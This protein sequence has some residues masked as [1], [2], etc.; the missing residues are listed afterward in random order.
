M[1]SGQN[2]L[3]HGNVT[4]CFD[5]LIFCLKDQVANMM[6]RA[7]RGFGS[8][9]DRVSAKIVTLVE[10]PKMAAK[11]THATTKRL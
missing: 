11:G 2:N 3:H 9:A 10:R 1:L 7:L 5:R 4:Q 6:V 8:E